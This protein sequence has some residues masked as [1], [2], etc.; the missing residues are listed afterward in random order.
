[1]ADKKKIT[2]QPVY[3]SLAYDFETAVPQR[4]PEWEPL[5]KPER[6]VV[7]PAAPDF[8]EQSAPLKRPKQHQTISPVSILGFAFAAAMLVFALIA[9]IQ[10]TVITDRTVAL[11][12]ELATLSLEQNRLLIEY[13]SVFNRS[14]IEEYATGTLGMQRPSEEQTV[15]LNSSAPD[16][17]VVLESG[18]GT[19][20]FFAELGEML[21]FVTEYFG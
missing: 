8:E 6:K 19:G 3:G 16:K 21:E 7:I 1:M 11:E 14:E 20:G 13:E 5:P 2:G 4:E 10:L 17:A 9:K 12:S 18:K 15:Y